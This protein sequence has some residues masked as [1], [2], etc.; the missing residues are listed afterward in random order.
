MTQGEI[1]APACVVFDLDDTLFLERE[2]VHSGFAAVDR[3][4]HNE[5]GATGFF[6]VA[7]AAFER[8]VRGTTF[9]MALAAI[10]IAPSEELVTN[11]VHVYRTHP[12]AIQV[13]PDAADCLQRLTGHVL[14]V[15]T[16]GPLESQR[17]KASAL[18]VS[19]WAA[20]VVFTATLGDGCG[21]PNPMAFR[22]VEEHVNRRGQDCLYVADNPAKDF[23]GPAALG[24]RTL[25]VRRPGALSAALEANDA[26]H[27]VAD[28]SSLVS[29]RTHAE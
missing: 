23:A 29:P 27:E 4:V 28:L 26:D 18:D 20:L 10:G 15:I 14:A 21:K 19:R 13:L 7:W 3:W 6:E 5:L 9:D 24:W 22:M 1:E 25:R 16:D 11:L 12:P 8:G 17:A 2:Y